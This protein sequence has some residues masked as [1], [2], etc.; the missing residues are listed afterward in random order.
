M[1]RYWAIPFTFISAFIF[2]FSWDLADGPDDVPPW[3]T[4]EVPGDESC[5]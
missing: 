4:G 3:F 5:D 1:N 2:S